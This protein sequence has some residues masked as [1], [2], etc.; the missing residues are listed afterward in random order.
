MATTP[1]KKLRV[2]AR[3][4]D[5]S[6]HF[7]GGFGEVRILHDQFLDRMVALKTIQ[8]AT[9]ADQLKNEVISI[10]EI[11]SKNVVEIY[12]LVFDSEGGLQ[13]IIEEYLSGD[14]L[15]D[16]AQKTRYDQ[17]QYLTTIFQIAS[18]IADIHGHGLVHRDIKL[19][20]MKKDSEGIVKLFD[21][22]LSCAGSDH[23]T[24]GGRGTKIYAAPELYSP[25]LDIER[26]LDTY[27]FGACC[28]AL[29]TTK[30]PSQLTETPPQQSSRAPSI[31]AIDKK[32]PPDLVRILDSTLD[33]SP[34]GRPSMS[35]VRD[36]IGRHLLFG[37]HRAWLTGG[38]QISAPSQSVTVG[39][40]VVGKIT[41]AYDG[42]RFYV[43][44]ISGDVFI[45][46]RTL[47][48]GDELPGSCVITIGGDG[49]GPMRSFV[50]FNVSHPEII[51]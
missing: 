43:A 30:I 3:Y 15:T 32:L 1:S 47:A 34:A 18:G 25:P 16:F 29:G 36:A 23:K 11:R 48:V 10:S 44:A 14:D 51:L 26:S 12:D 19:N 42:I 4:K 46:N 6:K 50:Q 35:Q 24:V 45:N 28:W 39:S 22:G 21:F 49:L 5:T 9:D 33:P 27:A 13:G 37:R 41:I 38:H 20:N 8:N 31:L 7:Q 17:K 2:P 40:N